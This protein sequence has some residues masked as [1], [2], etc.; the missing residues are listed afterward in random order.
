MN[1]M[2]GLAELLL[3][4]ELGMKQREY[5]HLIFQSGKTLQKMLNDVLDWSKMESG[6]V[7][8]LQQPVNVN[9]VIRRVAA[10]FHPVALSKNV[11]LVLDCDRSL[12]DTMLQS[13]DVRL[14]QIFTNFVGNSIKFTKQGSIT[15]SSKL[16]HRRDNSMDVQFDIQDTG[17]GIPPQDQAKIF[18]KFYQAQHIDNRYGGTG[19]GLP[20]CKQLVD[21][22]GGELT[23]KSVLGEGTTFTIKL[24]MHISSASDI[25]KHEDQSQLEWT[26]VTITTTP[27]RSHT[28]RILVAEDNFVNQKVITSIMQKFGLTVDVACNGAE[29]V[30]LAKTNTYD[31]IL[32]DLHMPVKDGFDATVEIRQ[33]NPDIPIVALT[34]DVMEEQ[35]ARCMEVKMNDII[36]KPF[37]QDSLKKKLS[38]W[39]D[40]NIVL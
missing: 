20:I 6:S 8:L 22:M 26:N 25:A 7:N 30:E 36:S 5:V 16:L 31:I 32:M 18:T 38:N 4:M 39:V 3:D 9:Q 33:F 23:M 21:L 24:T 34:A 11:K 37:T 15:V 40:V 14:I 27:V 29:A 2:I 1:G 10:M 12:D 19:L 17:I 28:N 35:K 13:D